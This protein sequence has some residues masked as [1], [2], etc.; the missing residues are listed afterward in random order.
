MT[1]ANSYL[2]HDSHCQSY[3]REKEPGLQVKSV[4]VDVGLDAGWS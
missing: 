2:F 4:E 1:V 3:L